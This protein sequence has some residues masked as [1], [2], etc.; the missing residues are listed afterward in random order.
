VTDSPVQ[1]EVVGDDHSAGEQK[2]AASTARDHIVDAAIDCILEEGLYKTSSNRIAI[3]AGMTW[4]AIQY[5][6]GSRQAILLAVY[7]RYVR[8]FEIR[9]QVATVQGD[10]LESRLR[11]FAK[12]VW[13]F[14][15]S[16][17]Y[18]AYLQVM[19]NLAA[20]QEM[21]TQTRALR[22]RLR[23]IAT[24]RLPH[25]MGEVLDAPPTEQA[26][27]EAAAYVTDLLRSLA[28]DHQLM[29]SMPSLAKRSDSS[30]NQV[31]NV[32]IEML[33]DKLTLISTDLNSEFV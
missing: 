22:A 16:P 15:R 11:T 25:L 28:T 20:D 13:D 10:T 1:R 29:S 33:V 30:L 26:V 3:R 27:I 6:F 4:G 21:S 24:K 32:L 14:H 8:S 9:L 23:A 5:Y 19:L 31:R 7:E 12:L 17:E 18:I 2:T